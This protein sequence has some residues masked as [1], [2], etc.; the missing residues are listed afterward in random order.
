MIRELI[1]VFCFKIVNA[2]ICDVIV[3]DVV[4]LVVE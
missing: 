1:Q 4:V 2:C 3:E